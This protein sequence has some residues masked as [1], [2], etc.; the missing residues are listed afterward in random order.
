[1]KQIF[2]KEVNAFLNSLI[3]YLVISVFL[4][5]TGV[6]LWIIPSS[7]ILSYMIADLGSM[8]A[9]APTLFLFLIP[10]VTMRS[11]A[12]EKKAG[13][14][15]LLLTRPLSDLD[16]ILGKFFAAFALVVFS[17]IPTLVYYGTV[18][19]LG[20]PMGN[21]DSAGVAGSYLGLFLLAAVFVSIGLLASSL[22]D[23]Q[24]I[25]FLLALVFCFLLYYGFDLLA[26]INVW[27]TW[28][29]YLSA[30]GMAH[31]YQ[32]LSKGV[33]DTRDVVY[34]F[35]LLAFMLS[36]TRLVLSTRNW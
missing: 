24:I 7:S 21:I 1:M 33:I 25:S 8:F 17:L 6:F 3:A 22:T 31:H 20:L 36:T 15:E 34:F 14:I 10:A 12:E 2:I 9:T 16:L 30:L 32:A 26:G 13:T 35:S 19:W 27:G 4:V 23:S 11:F 18:Y 29:E 5:T 28:S